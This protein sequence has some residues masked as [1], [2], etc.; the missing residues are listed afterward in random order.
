MAKS[1]KTR[2][3]KQEYISPGQGVL[4]CFGLPFS[5]SLSPYNRWVVLA[6]K[7]PWDLLVKVYLKQ[8]RNNSTGTG[9]INP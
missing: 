9:G 7:I 5:G 3:S 6:H 2:A 1:T 8:M 4:P